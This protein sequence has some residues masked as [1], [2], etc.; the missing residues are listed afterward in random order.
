MCVE[1][2]FN[3]IP[4]ERERSITVDYRGVTIGEY[5]PDLIVQNEVVVEVKSVFK[6][7]LVFA[8]Q[9]LTLM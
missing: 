9:V 2:A 6:Y 3:D 4:F 1:L 5:R 8:A 7:D